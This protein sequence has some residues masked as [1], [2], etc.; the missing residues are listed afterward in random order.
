MSRDF[1]PQMHYLISRENP[2]MYR[3]QMTFT[4]AGQEPIKKFT[5]EQ[6]GLMAKY[7]TLYPITADIFFDLRDKMSESDFERLNETFKELVNTPKLDWGKFPT[8]LVK[9]YTGELDPSFHYHEENDR[10]FKEWVMDEFCKDP[11]KGEFNICINPFHNQEIAPDGYEVYLLIKSAENDYSAFFANFEAPEL[12]ETEKD[13]GICL[14]AQYRKIGDFYELCDVSYHKNDDGNGWFVGS[15]S[16]DY[17]MNVEDMP[18]IERIDKICKEFIEG[19]E[20]GE[21]SDKDYS[22]EEVDEM[23]TAPDGLDEI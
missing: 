17:L 8:E 7:E 3:S 6:L 9:Y 13:R 2:E 12:T 22:F 15:A 19:Y 16:D 23:F 1:T 18:R 14:S 4:I 10:L 21:I 11:V 5:D 20:H